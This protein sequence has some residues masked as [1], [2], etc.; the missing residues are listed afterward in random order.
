MKTE[1]WIITGLLMA[2][3]MMVSGSVNA[4]RGNRAGNYSCC[5][6]IPG[7]TEKQKT[8]ITALEKSHRSDMDAMRAERRK[9]G[10]YTTRDAYQ[11]TV[12]E[13][14]NAHRDKVRNLLNEEQKVVFDNIQSRQGQG[15]YARRGGGGRGKGFQGGQGGRGGRGRW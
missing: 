5:E 9:S 2:L 7:L 14:V 6:G 11:A 4:Q 3:I 15:N 1:K 8:E 13:K 12:E 10:N